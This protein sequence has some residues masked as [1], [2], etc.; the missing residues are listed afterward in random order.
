[1][2]ARVN[3]LRINKILNCL[4]KNFFMCCL[5]CFWVW[6]ICCPDRFVVRNSGKNKISVWSK[7]KSETSVLWDQRLIYVQRFWWSELISCDED[8][9]FDV[10]TNNTGSVLRLAASVLVRC[11]RPNKKGET[12]FKLF[13]IYFK[14]YLWTWNELNFNIKVSKKKQTF[15]S[16]TYSNQLK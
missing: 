8:F 4:K 3:S 11:A 7:L 5:S 14:P 2:G 10:G 13:K 9:F 12:I 6:S 1:M 15:N 16:S